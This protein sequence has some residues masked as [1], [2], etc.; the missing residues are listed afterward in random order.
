M[1]I[2]TILSFFFSLALMA[3]YSQSLNPPEP[4][5]LVEREITGSEPHTYA[6][7]LSHGEFIQIIATQKNVDIV[8]QLVDPNGKQIS[9]VNFS[10]NFGARESISHLATG[11]GEYRLVVRSL[12][13][14]ATKRTYEIVFDRNATPS[15]TDLR[16]VEAERLLIDGF[17][18]TLKSNNEAAIERALRALPIWREL[19]DGYWE[20]ETLTLLGSAHNSTRKSDQAADYYNQALALRRQIGDRA[21]ESNVLSDLGVVSEGL[22]KRDK[23]LEYFSQARE[24][25]REL[26]D[27]AG[28]ARVIHLIAN[29]TFN[30]GKFAE[31]IKHADEMLEIFQAIGD[32]EGAGNSYNLRGNSNLNLARYEEAATSYEKALALSKETGNRSL[33]GRVLHNSGVLKTRLGNFYEAIAL[34]EQALAIR[35]ETKEQ[36]LKAGTLS[37]LG[38]MLSNVGEYER[39]LKYLDQALS[40]A[41]ELG[42][43][44]TEVE[45]LGGISRLRYSLGEYDK[46]LE[47]AQT[48]VSIA[49]SL[50]LPLLMSRSYKIL[51]QA[52]FLQGRF[53]KEI[54]LLEKALPINRELKDRGSEADN[55]LVIATDY[56]RLGRYDR[57]LEILQQALDLSKEIKSRYFEATAIANIGIVYTVQGKYQQAA[58]YHER[59]LAFF[60]ETKDQQQQGRI[61][62]NLGEGLLKQGRPQEAIAIATQ[63][64]AILSDVKDRDAQ[65]IVLGNLGTAYVA[66]GQFDKAAETLDKAL[67]IARELKTPERIREALIELARLEINRGNLSK[68]GSHL[69][70]SLNSLERSRSDIYSPQSRAAFLAAEQTSLRLYIDLLMRMRV[71]QPEMAVLAL[72]T[73]EKSRARV[74]LELLGESGI[75]IRQDVDPKLV[76]EEQRLGQKVQVWASRL[77]KATNPALVARLKTELSELEV[78]LERTQSGIRKSSPQYA[79][80]TQ[81][82]PLKLKEIQQQLD[83]DTMLLEYALGDERSYLWAVTRDSL[84]GYELPK[85]EQITKAALQVYELLTARSTTRRG[86]TANAKQNRID[87]AEAKLQAASESLS[88]ILLAPVAAQLGNKR[89]VVVADGA[90]QYIP[91]G[92]LPVGERR[93]DAERGRRGDREERYVPLIVN[94]EV[95]SLPSASA[96]AIQRAELAG[97]RAAPKTLAVIADPVFDRSDTRLKAAA[98]VESDETTA[99]AIGLDDVRS[100]EHLAEKSDDKTTTA[101]LIIPRLP[102]TRQEA[103]RLL[104]LAPGNS[105]FSATDFTANRTTVLDGRLN[106]YRYVHFATHGVLNS[107]RPGLSSLVLSMVDKDGNQQDGFLRAN[108]IYNLKLSAELVV[109]SACQTGLGKEIK[110]EG[111]V[112][113]TRGF[114]YAG[115]PRVVVSLWSV[116]DRA[117]ADLMTRFYQKMLKEGVRPAAALRAAQVSMLQR[118]QWQSPYYWAAFTMQGDWR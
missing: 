24:M 109:L 11:T 116:N 44:Q 1:A 34:Y 101:R 69:E 82:E 20:A 67:E 53:E 77:E 113:L 10:R 37:N 90:L 75:N 103:T 110:G 39:A 18:D 31:A 60:R 97:R 14:S 107:E 48:A 87:G 36:G 68:A 35:E 8:I 42:N 84:A 13:N 9:E 83:P 49:E 55:L 41:R 91:F 45:A 16:R 115:A 92:M 89:L 61:L 112:G 73:S 56:R 2:L 64:L 52:Y 72:E 102:F 111:L 22:N 26:K 54:E 96:L 30:L 66:S 88:Q 85:E 51:G 118:K 27:L 104:A 32:R 58:E 78:E 93:G 7:R 105:S 62:I 81:P 43:R 79:A 59:A 106:E 28:E 117:T 3:G 114:M 70:E 46:A 6:I 23:A 19:R 100:L 99:G 47:D 12:S 86:E 57:A 40:L 80:I 63:A 71:T 74:L 21:G 33:E 17:T 29:T 76:A 98:K 15:Q 108:D 5:K 95:V 65:S 4:G 38:S 25:K 94:H 50:K